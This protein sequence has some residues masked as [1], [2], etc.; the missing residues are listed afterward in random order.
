MIIQSAPEI[1]DE[2]KF[3]TTKENVVGELA[4]WVIRFSTHLLPDDFDKGILEFWEQ[5][6]PNIICSNERFETNYKV[7]RSLI[8]ETFNKCPSILESW[9]HLHKLARHIANSITLEAKYWQLHKE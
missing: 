6:K 4:N 5:F 9:D 7:L 8:R 3:K 2:R 1:W